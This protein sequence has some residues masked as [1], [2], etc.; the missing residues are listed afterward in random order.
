MGFLVEPVDDPETWAGRISPI[1]SSDTVEGLGKA[2]ILG[3]TGTTTTAV[4]PNTDPPVVVWT[5]KL[6]K[7]GARDQVAYAGD[8]FVCDG[9]QV[10][11]LKTPDLVAKFTA[12][13][14]LV[15]DDA[16]PV[17]V[18]LPADQVVV[19]FP[20]PTSPCGPFTYTATTQDGEPL[21]VVS[22]TVENGVVTL[23]GDGLITGHDYTFTVAVTTQYGETPVTSAASDAITAI[24]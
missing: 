7:P 14:D 11:V 9:H 4:Q 22:Q 12:D 18:A 8:W 23:K 5:L 13:V 21:N 2:A 1:D 16:A 17:A 10:Q 24:L 6:S 3:Y 19:T 20:Q 15:W